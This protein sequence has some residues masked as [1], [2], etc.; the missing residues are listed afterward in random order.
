MVGVASVNM[1]PSG[2]HAVDFVL[3]G[4]KLG[5]ECTFKIARNRAGDHAG[6]IHIRV[7]SAGETKVN[8]ANHLIVFVEQNVAEI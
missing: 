5:E 3:V 6:N 4:G 1:L 8:D 2:L 7:A